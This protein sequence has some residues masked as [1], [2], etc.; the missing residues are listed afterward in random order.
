MITAIHARYATFKLSFQ[1]H[2]YLL[3]VDPVVPFV[4]DRWEQERIQL[5][6]M[7]ADHARELTGLKRAVEAQSQLV[8]ESLVTTQR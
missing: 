5:C 2:T 1:V 7:D 4:D 3:V 6:D 8:M